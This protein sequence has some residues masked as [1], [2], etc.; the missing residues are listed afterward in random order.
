[1]ERELGAT[2]TRNDTCLGSVCIQGRCRERPQEQRRARLPTNS[3]CGKG[4]LCQDGICWEGHCVQTCRAAAD[5]PVGAFCITVSSGERICT[6]PKIPNLISTPPEDRE[7]TVA[8][9]PFLVIPTAIFMV[10][11]V[12]YVSYAIYADVFST[13]P[14]PKPPVP[15][16]EVAATPVQPTFS[17]VAM[18]VGLSPAG[19]TVIPEP[20]VDDLPRTPIEKREFSDVNY[21]AAPISTVQPGPELLALEPELDSQTLWDN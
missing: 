1:M 18:Y 13:P 5:C 4:D 2:C 20:Y 9:S 7:G 3:S 15:T 16:I 11:L 6:A 19:T 12:V 10:M 21:M 14:K 8:L 17:R